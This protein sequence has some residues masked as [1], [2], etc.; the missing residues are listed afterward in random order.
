M[1]VHVKMLESLQK[2]LEELM[3]KKENLHDLVERKVYTVD[4]F[5]QRSQVIAQRIEEKYQAMENT[6]A[7]LELE[8]RR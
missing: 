8:R 6:K 5:I 1:K 2:Q 3:L 7:E 4:D